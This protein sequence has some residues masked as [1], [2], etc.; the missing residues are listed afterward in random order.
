MF[1]IFN[2]KRHKSLFNH[3]DTKEN[4][5]EHKGA[6]LCSR[7]DEI[8]IFKHKRHKSLFNHEDTKGNHKGHKG[9]SLCWRTDKICIFKHKR[10]K[11]FM[12]YYFNYSSSV[13][14]IE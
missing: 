1:T 8:C 4:Y 3:E 9:A 2:N 6:S 7:T 13:S 14:K 11:S 12:F 5:K 10:Y